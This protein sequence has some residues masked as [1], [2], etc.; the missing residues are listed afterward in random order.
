M[1]TPSS[2]RPDKA[3]IPLLQ[4]KP[5]T[6]YFKFRHIYGVIGTSY[7]SYTDEKNKDPVP[8]E[9]LKKEGVSNPCV[10]IAHLI[11]MDK[12]VLTEFKDAPERSQ[13]ILNGI[14]S[15]QAELREKLG[16]NP[17]VYKYKLI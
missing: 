1:F 7:L 16:L 8:V 11:L 15:H 2:E 5:L 6:E 12:R 17:N 9:F 4:N 3:L 14:M 10:W 13:A